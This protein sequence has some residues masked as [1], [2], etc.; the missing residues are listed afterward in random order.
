MQIVAFAPTGEIVPIVQIEGHDGSEVAGP[1]FDPS[2]TRLYFS[3]QRGAG[4]PPTGG[5]TYEISGPFF[6]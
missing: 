2:G 6:V 3:S 1:A 5:I 4:I